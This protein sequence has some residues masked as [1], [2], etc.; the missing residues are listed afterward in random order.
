MDNSLY[1]KVLGKIYNAYKANPDK[2]L[3]WTGAAGWGLSSLAQMCG[4][5]FNSKISNKE[6]SFLLPQEFMDAVVNIT[7]YIVLT[8]SASKILKKLVTTG[9]FAPQ[10]VRQYLSK[11]DALN[12]K[13]AKLD[14]DLDKVM[15]S[16]SKFPVDAYIAN[17]NFITTVG[18]IGAGIVST[19]IVTPL[20]RNTFAS[21]VQKRYINNKKA[22][23]NPLRTVPDVSSTY[24]KI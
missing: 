7:A 8:K 12:K 2:M 24:L 10:S 11:N 4:I 19:S 17:K 15:E 22:E 23:K 6:K 3:I 14:L 13:A 5:V 9:K 1:Q 20:L 16:D 18:T 21:T